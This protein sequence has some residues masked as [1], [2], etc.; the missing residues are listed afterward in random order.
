MIEETSIYFDPETSMA[1]AGS[2][3]IPHVLKAVA[4]RYIAANPPNPFQFRG[5]HR[6]GFKGTGVLSG[7]IDIDLLEKLPNAA[8]GSFSFVAARFKKQY[9]ET[10][11][12]VSCRG[13]VI[14][15]LNGE[16]IWQSSV[17][18]DVNVNVVTF[19]TLPTIEGWNLFVIRCQKVTSGFGC[20]IGPEDHRWKW[21]TW[22][23]PFARRLGQGGFVYS[24]PTTEVL[25]PSSFIINADEKDTGRVWLPC[26]DWS[27]EDTEK[28]PF[29]RLFPVGKW[30]CAWSAVKQEYPFPKK[31]HFRLSGADWYLDGKMLSAAIEDGQD[32]FTSVCELQ[33]GVHEIFAVS[34]CP[35][36][37]LWKPGFVA[38]Y[39]DGNALPQKLPV[40]AR[41]VPGNWLYLG[42]FEKKPD[43][44]SCASLYGLFGDREKIYWYADERD[45]VL[46]P[47]LE[48]PCFG[49]WNYPLGVTLYG[50]TQTSRVLGRKDIQ[51]YV[52]AHI[53]QIV[54]THAYSLWDA[55]VYGYPE[56]NNQIVGLEMLDDCGSFGS[57]MLEY[58]RDVKNEAV[59]VIADRIA[60]HMKYKQERRENGAFYRM[61]KGNWMENTLW[62]DDLYMS[63]PFLCRYAALSGDLSYIDDAV[64]QVKG[65]KKFLFMP[66]YK[67]MSHVYDFK[68]NTAT[69]M[70][71]GRGNGWCLFSLSELLEA[72]SPNHKDRGFILDF[73]TS[74]CEG[75]SA[76]QGSRGLW[77]QFLIHSDSYEETSCTAMFIY[78]FC[79]AVRF[80]WIKGD[81]ADRLFMA[82]KRG[83]WG[84][85]SVSIDCGGNIY[86]VCQG[87]SYSFSPDYYK[88]VLTPV[89]NDTHGIGIV[90]LAGI[91]LA[92]LV[93]QT[94]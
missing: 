5:F 51:S 68:Y 31:V 64:T 72:M 2:V 74:L 39:E 60:D 85:C 34:Q 80:G 41:G 30:A 4:D 6:D 84:L 83:W 46:R 89:T 71:W 38:E 66:E 67:V 19:V 8:E 36:S 24:E 73:F 63:I 90:L 45:T 88:Y 93:N 7:K 14:I 16:K 79:R 29:E 58:Y 91:E 26:R 11:I 28:S 56:I 75:Y 57:A 32:T 40:P 94:G 81:L 65:F 1:A 49:R 35:S 12:S 52:G 23:A 82:A 53:A 62:V 87:S 13:P 55:E 37:G 59:C 77:H 42:P 48:N 22:L 10:K 17:R 86:G 47:Y 33:A 92:K 61:R 27:G 18:E 9:A 3:D 78:A 76:L 25:D 50:L 54:K 20:I 44:A 15:W 69:K 21:I 43:A 70:P